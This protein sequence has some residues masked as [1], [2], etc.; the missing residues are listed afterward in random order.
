MI[1]VV[2][3]VYGH[4]VLLFDAVQSL[5]RADG[6][7][8]VIV[9][10]GCPT[11]ET[12]LA[13]LGL[14]ELAP[15]IHYLRQ[16]NCGLSGARNR[17]I[18]YVMERLPEAEAIFFL[19]ADN[20]L[21]DW[22][23]AEMRRMLAEYPDD[24]WFYPDIRMFGLE[25]EADYAGSFSPL[26]ESLVNICEAGSLVRRRIFES[27]LRFSEEL[28][29][30]FEDWDFWLTAIERGF[31]GR[32]FPSS[33][34]RYRKRPESMLANSTRAE[35]QIR[36]Q[37]ESRHPW[38]L[39]IVWAVGAEHRT[40]PRFAV[41]LVDLDIVR[42]T[43]SPD[44]VAEELSLSDYVAR[45]WA[46]M[47]APKQY[48]AGAI[49]I[50]TTSLH[51]A[52]LKGAGLL[53]WV[54]YDLEVRL[55]DANIATFS[56]ARHSRNRLAISAP[57]IGPVAD[58]GLA[59]LSMDLLRSICRDPF[60]DWIQTAT[61]SKPMLRLS[62]R[63]VELPRRS[64]HHASLGDMVRQLVRLCIDLRRSPYAAGTGLPEQDC[65]L[66]TPNRADLNSKLRAKFGGGVLPPAIARQ[67]PEIAFALPSFE[68]GGVE[69]VALCVARALRRQGFVVSLLL[70]R[71]RTAQVSD[72]FAAAF[73][74][75]F[76]LDNTEFENWTGP[77]YW[78]TALSR[79]SISGEQ[80]NELNL[81]SIFDAVIACHAGDLAGLFGALRRRGVVT[82]AYLH[83]F[84]AVET[85]RNTGHPHIAL[86]Y[87]HALDLFLCCS[88]DI[89][90]Q[91]HARGV[92]S[93]KL[94]TVPNAGGVDIPPDFA[95]ATLQARRARGGGPLRV[96]FI[97]RL[98]PQKGLD[99][100][101]SI[102]AELRER[103]IA[104]I[105]MAGR[106]LLGQDA[107]LEEIGELVEEPLFGRD[108]LEAY[109]W[110]DVLLL[111]SRYEGLPL[112]VI[113]AMQLGVVP[114][115]AVSGAL[116]EVVADGI[117][118]FLVSQEHCVLETVAHVATLAGDRA[119]LLAMAE[120]AAR[121][122]RDWDSAVADFVVALRGLLAKQA[123]ARAR[124]PRPAG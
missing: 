15:H 80:A 68:F 112:T 30:G 32:H 47:R 117:N 88:E 72:E 118:G 44:M 116:A 82:A 23:L 9:D 78:G 34:F 94:V 38:M 45:F 53:G 61:D 35:M 111:P 115:C 13:G 55:R 42:L 67:R 5:A 75:V 24:D 91:M 36:A 79:W 10:D 28:K 107:A 57:E 92:P 63:T 96:L 83:L 19:D 74:R 29:L 49:V 27:G 16:P 20:M 69:R 59:A 109:A 70:L 124:L 25:W 43:S 21:S 40:V 85:Q 114:I 18:A 120:A 66:G 119:R 54:L 58:A 6:A 39:D 62:R 4:S 89:A 22:S 76:F 97:G 3:P 122:R 105:R 73:D 87:E 77:S 7:S 90:L 84:D 51:L 46:A 86:A 12:S 60:D 113:E 104:E 14:A 17:G 41:H 31:R 56:L 8:V 48:H 37:L 95:A 103:E 123:S 106:P 93:A 71:S 110:A 11:L 33:G 101:V 121:V 2:I 98:D 50:V 52:A 99:R 102:A 1:A 108:Q 26:I 81:V 100:L 64:P 65:S